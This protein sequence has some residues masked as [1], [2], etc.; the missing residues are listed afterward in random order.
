M[1]I[2]YGSLL[3]SSHFS[4]S[5][6]KLNPIA[7]LQPSFVIAHILLNLFEIVSYKKISCYLHANLFVTQKPLLN[8]SKQ[9]I[10]NCVC[11]NKFVISPYS[12]LSCT[13]PP[14]V[15]AHV[16]FQK[17]CPTRKPRI[18]P[19][20]L[21]I[22]ILHLIRHKV[23]LVFGSKSSPVDFIFKKSARFHLPISTAL[24]QAFI[25]IAGP[26]ASMVS[27]PTQ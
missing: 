12:I 23:L 26:W 7:L 6:R 8:S 15:L 21:L 22:H 27:F 1:T 13:S 10:S 17:Y 20:F 19:T 9:G 4:F 14:N 11:P 3:Y 16:L 2:I 25:S 18:H 24:V 5:L